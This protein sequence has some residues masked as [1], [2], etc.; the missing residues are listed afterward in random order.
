LGGVQRSEVRAWVDNDLEPD[1]GKY[2]DYDT[3]MGSNANQVVRVPVGML[4]C[5]VLTSHWNALATLR[6]LTLHDYA[7][8]F[9]ML[10]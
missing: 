5:T 3:P 10:P 8:P 2:R 9:I 7:L 1:W 6:L 4:E